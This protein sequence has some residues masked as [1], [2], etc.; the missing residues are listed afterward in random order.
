MQLSLITILTSQPSQIPTTLTSPRVLHTFFSTVSMG[1]TEK[2]EV[3]TEVGTGVKKESQTNMAIFVW[4]FF[5]LL[6]QLQSQLQFFL[7]FPD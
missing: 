4:D 7:S 6:A 2:T 5:E 1:K 3:G